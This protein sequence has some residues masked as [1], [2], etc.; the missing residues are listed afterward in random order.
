MNNLCKGCRN[1]DEI[2]K[3][4]SNEVD[5]LTK[6]CVDYNL[7]LEVSKIDQRYFE[8]FNQPPRNRRND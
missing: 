2:N 6:E 4:L 8:N 1:R 3:V 7:T 5:R